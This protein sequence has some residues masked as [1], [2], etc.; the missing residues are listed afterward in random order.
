MAAVA[1]G[2]EMALLCLETVGKR[3]W[4]RM[5]FKDYPPEATSGI[6]N[7]SFF[8]WLNPLFIRGFRKILLLDD[9]YSV[10]DELY[11]QQLQS[12]IQAAWQKCI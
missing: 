7:R 10:D 3:P 6:I 12:R 4:L 1:L 2:V 11:S 5:P 8:W 9:L